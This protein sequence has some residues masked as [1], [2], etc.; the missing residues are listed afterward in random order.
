MESSILPDMRSVWELQEIDTVPS[1]LIS[2]AQA[3]I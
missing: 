2:A 1:S 3:E